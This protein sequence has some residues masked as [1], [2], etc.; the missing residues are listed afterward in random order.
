M[1]LILVILSIALNAMAL[2]GKVRHVKT[3][4]NYFAFDSKEY[5]AISYKNDENW[6]T[7]WKTPGDAGTPTTV[8]F[9]QDGKELKLKALEWP[10]PR[11][12]FEQ[13]NL[14]AYGYGGVY[15]FF[16]EIP[17]NLKNKIKSKF[18][19]TS[20]WLVC[21]DVCIPSKVNITTKLVGSNFEYAKSHH[22][23]QSSSQLISQLKELPTTLNSPADLPKDLEIYLNKDPSGETNLSLNYTYKVAS[24]D[25][26][27][28]K[29]NLLTP[30]PAEPFGFKHEFLYF[31]PIS[32]TVYGKM[33]LE[34]DGDLKEPEIPFPK[35]GIFDRE[36]TFKFIFRETVNSRPV[37]ISKSFKRFVAGGQKALDEFYKGLDNQKVVKKK[38]VDHN[39]F[40]I[41][42]YAFLGGLILNLMPC[43]L[44]VISLKLFGLIA[45]RDGKQTSIL[46]HNLFYSLGIMS[47]F[48]IMASIVMGLKSSGQSIGWGF[49]LQSPI[50][51][52]LLILAIFVLALNMFGLFEFR[53]PF[54]NKLGNTQLKKG[55]FGDFMSGVLTTILSTP[56]SAPF[57]GTALTFAFTTSTFNIYL[58]FIFIAFGLSFPFILTGFLPGLIGFLPKPGAWMDKLKN[59]LGLTLLLTAVWL[60]DVLMNIIDPQVSGLFINALI[61]LTFFGF[62]FY[63]KMSQRSFFRIIF[64]VIPLFFFI[65]ILKQDLLKPASNLTG[66]AMARGSNPEWITWSKHTLRNTPGPVFIDFTAKW[67]LTCKVNK[68]LV[69]ETDDFQDFTKKNNI[70]LMLADWTKYDPEITKWL[71]EYNV[72]SVPAYFI[73]TKAGEIKFLGET[74]S[75][76][77]IKNAL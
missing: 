18:T 15:S 3:S 12:Y 24:R 9:K 22:F 10:A 74:I 57:L 64:G 62:Y 28:A 37:V 27:K 6:H 48:M 75:I 32:N 53:T 1:K 8:S 69:L 42:I 76:K 33:V 40:L 2:G 72:V 70:K 41:M 46:K 31:D 4:L 67:C 61:T 55:V 7:Y 59:F 45:H 63:N 51:V 47:T 36:F 35:S 77:K 23:E 73:K 49:Q 25:F 16:F 56:C 21:K 14:L 50:F 38:V 30:F 39:I 17:K 65:F 58:T 71:A 54:G 68:K 20:K 11:R 5:I 26:L 44:P 60:H 34:W 66:S 52:C 29:N 19:L 43:V 13:G